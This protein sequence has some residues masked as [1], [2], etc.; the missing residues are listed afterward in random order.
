MLK[1]NSS[2]ETNSSC[3]CLQ[4]NCTVKGHKMCMHCL[5]ELQYEIRCI[6]RVTENLF[7]LP[8]ILKNWKS[9]LVFLRQV[10]WLKISLWEYTFFMWVVLVDFLKADARRQ[11][12]LHERIDDYSGVWNAV[13]LKHILKEKSIFR[14]WSYSLFSHLLKVFTAEWEWVTAFLCIAFQWRCSNMI[15][16][17]FAHIPPVVSMKDCS[18]WTT[19]RSLL[20]IC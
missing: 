20:S 14:K 3:F 9:L 11:M 4:V 7:L 19:E 13:Q 2:S 6:C 12:L 1:G 15:W 16:W 5:R 8:E 17:F 10:I 18:V